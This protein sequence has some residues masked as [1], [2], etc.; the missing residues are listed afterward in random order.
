MEYAVCVNT[1]LD[2]AQMASTSP[3]KSSGTDRSEPSPS[4]MA[5]YNFYD[6][7]YKTWEAANSS[8]SAAP[9]RILPD[10]LPSFEGVFQEFLGLIRLEP[11]FSQSYL[12]PPTSLCEEALPFADVDCSEV[13]IASSLGSGPSDLKASLLRYS[14]VAFV[15]GVAVMV[16]IAAIA[17]IT[18]LAV[19]SNV[20]PS[21][22]TVLAAVRARAAPGTSRQRVRQQCQWG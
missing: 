7:I 16:R 18:G 13:A 19:T 6:I 8:A 14:R 2:A 1:A 15:Q 10:V 12:T 22:I 3:V 9:A 21:I 4:A 5:A 11:F 17:V 20:L